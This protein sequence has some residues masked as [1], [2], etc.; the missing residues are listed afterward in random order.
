M[1]GKAEGHGDQLKGFWGGRA[2]GEVEEVTVR[3]R[4]DQDKSLSR[5]DQRQ[6]TG[7]RGVGSRRIPF[8]QEGGF[9]GA[10]GPAGKTR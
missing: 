7:P 6:G 4:P 1:R 10:A 8:G 2:A 9:T 3:R 5:G